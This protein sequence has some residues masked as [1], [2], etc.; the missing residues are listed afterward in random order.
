MPFKSNINIEYISVTLRFIYFF[1]LAIIFIIGELLLRCCYFKESTHR[2]SIRTDDCFV[3]VVAAVAAKENRIFIII[4]LSFQF[5]FLRFFLFHS[6]VAFHI[7]YIVKWVY[8]LRKKTRSV[9]PLGWNKQKESEWEGESEREKKHNK[10]K[11]NRRKMCQWAKDDIIWAWY[12]RIQCILY[13]LT[14]DYTSRSAS[15]TQAHQFRTD[16]HTPAE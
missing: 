10:N 3:V 8:N 11:T 4:L 6:S 9:F 13:T 12:A 1:F 15:P 14:G 2:R 5:V 16:A 7:D